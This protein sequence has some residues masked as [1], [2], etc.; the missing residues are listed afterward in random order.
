[1]SKKFKRILFVVLCLLFCTLTP[2]VILYSQG[3]RWDFQQK[4][5]VKVG[6]IFLKIRPTG[7]QVYLNSKLVKNTN[8]IFDSVYLGNLLPNTYSVRIEKD[9]YSSWEK[10][11]KVVSK[12]VTEAKNIILFRNIPEVV[13]SGINDIEKVLYEDANTLI[14]IQYSKTE[15]PKLLVIDKAKFAIV[16]SISFKLFSSVFEKEEITKLLPF[17]DMKRFLVLT[18]KGEVFY[19]NLTTSPIQIKQ[20]PIKKRVIKIQIY[21][22]DSN[23]VFAIAEKNN[24]KELL[25][26]KLPQFTIAPLEITPSNNYQI[27]DFY[28]QK[29]GDIFWLAENGF[30]YRGELKNSHLQTVE[31]LN[32]KPLSKLKTPKLIIENKRKIFVLDQEKLFYLNPFTH[33]FLLVFEKVQNIQFSPSKKII[34]ATTPHQVWLFYLEKEYNQPQREAGQK[35]LLEG[36]EENIKKVLWYDNYHLIVNLDNK[37]VIIE[38]DNRSRVNKAEIY[39]GEG[40]I[41]S[42]PKKDRFIL[43]KNK[44]LLELKPI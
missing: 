17:S 10:Q 11:L 33:N 12:Q 6:G 1:M 34:S 36:F 19:I 26:I 38:T 9:G 37:I 29:N 42:S 5:I 8:F 18:K 22:P 21:P 13:E 31:I 44:T 24:K 25:L 16:K 32:L 15:S 40:E 4:K 20:I 39:T 30:L 2:A 14:L 35:V 7:C 41:F 3:Y 27:L 43:Y 23:N 28:I